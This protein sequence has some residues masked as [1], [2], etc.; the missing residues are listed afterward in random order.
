MSI[1]KKIAVIVFIGAFLVVT[2]PQ[3]DAYGKDK[4]FWGIG[5]YSQGGSWF[6]IGG[7]IAD[8]VNR[9]SEGFN[10]TP[11]PTTGV[12]KNINLINSGE[13]QIAFAHPFAAYNAFKGVGSWDKPV[14]VSQLWNWNYTSHLTPI[15]LKKSGLKN[16]KDLKG[17]V[18][19]VGPPGSST[20]TYSKMIADVHG[21][22][23]EK[24]FKPRY[25][26]LSQSV[27]ALKDGHIDALLLTL[28]TPAPALIDL[29]TTRKLSFLDIDM[30]KMKELTEKWPGYVIEEIAPKVYKGIREGGQKFLAYSALTVCNS[31][32]DTDLVY[33]F[34]KTLFDN[35]DEFGKVHPAAAALT[36]EG[37]VSPK[38]IPF[39]P[40]AVKYFKEK[41]GW[42]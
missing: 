27:E 9:K 20:L 23:I 22:D 40:G 17:K 37:G 11:L 32:L 35:L 16:W 6:L 7:A 21:W 30:S 12:I 13:L 2:V 8:I 29:S 39:H 31:D 19:S 34:V 14:P 33:K 5:T 36:I 41:G 26:G 10:V 42:K 3:N 4:V 1:F 38:V 18:V 25:Y 15:A 24:D 28:T